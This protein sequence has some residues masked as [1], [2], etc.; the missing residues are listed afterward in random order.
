[1]GAERAFLFVCAEGQTGDPELRK[2][3]DAG[4]LDLLELV[5]YSRTVVRKVQDERKPLV[6]SCT[7]EGEA[8]GA[9]SVVAH[10]LRSVIAA[11]LLHQDQLVGV[12][13]LDTRVAKGIFTA[14]DVDVLTA[15]GQLLA[16]AFETTKAAQNE[17]RRQ[18]L[19]RDL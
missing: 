11:P 8:I 4:G 14:E 3:R 16:S 18:A 12:M 1:L 2:G 19:E 9:L 7:E 13:Y 17:L 6:L 5:G 15:A 10:N